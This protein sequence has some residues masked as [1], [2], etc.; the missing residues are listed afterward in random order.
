MEDTRFTYFIL[1]LE[2]NWNKEFSNHTNSRIWSYS[3]NKSIFE[4]F[5]LSSKAFCD[6]EF[7]IF[8]TNARAKH[9]EH[10]SRGKRRLSRFWLSRM[11][12]IAENEG[13]SPSHSQERWHFH[14]RSY[15]Q[16]PPL[17]FFVLSINVVLYFILFLMFVSVKSVITLLCIYSLFNKLHS[18]LL[19]C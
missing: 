14:R 7:H 6:R 8:N 3:N 5:A 1:L 9:A 11:V 16:I 19:S 18:Q 15:S 12:R 4:Q 2:S 13:D 17:I 10:M